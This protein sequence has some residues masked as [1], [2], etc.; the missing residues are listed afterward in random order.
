MGTMKE[1]DHILFNLHFP[2]EELRSREIKRLTKDHTQH[3]INP[4]VFQ[5]Q[6]KYTLCT[7]LQHKSLLL[8]TPCNTKGAL[9]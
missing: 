1:N 9:T 6:E 2:Y 8:R 7:T 3:S 4:H 5:A